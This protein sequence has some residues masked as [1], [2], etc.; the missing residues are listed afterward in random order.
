MGDMSKLSG[1]VED[2]IAWQTLK[3]ESVASKSWLC[4]KRGQNKERIHT[5][6]VN[7]VVEDGVEMTQRKEI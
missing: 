6:K 5:K 4:L 7:V 2:W 3:I 1:K